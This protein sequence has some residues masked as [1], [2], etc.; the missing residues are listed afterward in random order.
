MN[1]SPH[2]IRLCGLQRWKAGDKDAKGSELHF[3]HFLHLRALIKRH[4]PGELP[5]RD[6]V[7]AKYADAADSFLGS[8]QDFD[9]Y[10]MQ[11]PSNDP[12]IDVDSLGLFAGAK[13]VQNQVLLDAY[14]GTSQDEADSFQ[15][16][17]SETPLRKVKQVMMKQGIDFSTRPPD[18]DAA[19]EQI[20]NEAL[21]SFASALTRKWMVQQT[22]AA[23]YPSEQ[24]PTKGGSAAP[25]HDWKTVAD[26]TMARDRFHIRERIRTND[27]IQEG[28]MAGLR[29]NT[30]RKDNF[31]KLADNH[32]YGRIMTSETDGS[33]YRISA[34]ATEILAIVEAKKRLRKKNRLKIE[35]QEAAEILA[36]LNVRLRTESAQGGGKGKGPST[37]RRGML[38]PK[39][40][41]GKSG[42]KSRWVFN[43]SLS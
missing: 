10:I 35:W 14:L 33:L 41:A 36:W 26:W 24:T 11:V 42:E 29:A 27:P 18:H 43:L 31:V 22:S 4:G 32:E 3:E 6:L 2:C 40:A 5:L 21:I 38:E 13:L 19:D 9:N 17:T 8:W 37:E 39:P 34:N 15:D 23:V 16:S 20:V 25:A 12:A 30:K 1:R 7:K 28:H